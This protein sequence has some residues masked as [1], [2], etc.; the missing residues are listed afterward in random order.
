MP[1]SRRISDAFNA[2]LWHISRRAHVEIYLAAAHDGDI[3]HVAM[4]NGVA[5]DEGQPTAASI[6]SSLV[7][8]A[9]RMLQ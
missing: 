7:A 3:A 9:V 4:M 1:N 8:S 2:A 6:M 5:G